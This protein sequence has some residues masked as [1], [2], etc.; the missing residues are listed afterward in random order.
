MVLSGAW[1]GWRRWAGI[2]L[3]LGLLVTATGTAGAQVREQPIA[4]ETPSGSLAGTLALPAATGRVPVVLLIAGSGPTDRDGNGPVAQLRNDSLKLLAAALA[5]AGFASVRY[6]KR[7]IG[8]SRAA[9]P[10]ESAL[11]FDTFVD[12]AAAWVA[13]L[14]AEP[15]FASVSIVGHSEGALVGL[16][17]ARRGGVAGYVSVA[18]IAQPVGAIL[19]TQLAGKLPPDLAATSETILASLERGQPVSDVP[20]ALASLYRPSVQPFLISEL[21][22]VPGAEMAALAIPALIVQGTTDIQVGV[23]EARALKAAQPRAVLAL[24]PGMNHP[25]KDV[26]ADMARQM[27]SYGDPALPLAP[28]LVDAI[29]GFLRALPAGG[30]PAAP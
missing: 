9:G 25:L 3:W 18:G 29:T 11:R 24:I 8:A 14:R 4:L 1:Q 12:D 27:A 19:R 6:D 22:I 16:L 2:V 26:P 5:D 20:P 21:K 13:R 10:T 28:G 23:G 7:G 15:R 30:A 17:A